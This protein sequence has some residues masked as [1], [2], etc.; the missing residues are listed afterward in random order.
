MRGSQNISAPPP[1]SANVPS[2]PALAAISAPSPL[3][4]RVQAQRPDGAR[5]RILERLRHLL[6]TITRRFQPAP[7]LCKRLGRDAGERL[8]RPVVKRVAYILRQCV[9]NSDVPVGVAD[10]LDH[11]AR[12]AHHLSDHELTAT[13]ADVLRK[14]NQAFLLRMLNV[15]NSATATEVRARIPDHATGDRLDLIK[16]CIEQALPRAVVAD[17]IKSAQNA[18]EHARPARSTQLLREALEG[19]PATLA[20]Y[21][22][23]PDPREQRG[24]VARQ[25]ETLEPWVLAGILHHAHT[26][27]LVRL[28][29]DLVLRDAVNKELLNRTGVLATRLRQQVRSFTPTHDDPAAFVQELAEM[30]ATLDEL[31]VFRQTF[32]YLEVN[33]EPRK[34][35]DPL[36]DSQ[37][38]PIQ[39]QI[40][41]LAAAV[42]GKSHFHPGALSDEQLV[43]VSSSLRS[44][45]AKDLLGSEA[46]QSAQRRCLDRLRREFK[47]SFECAATSDGEPKPLLKRLERIADATRALAQA[48]AAFTADD[49]PDPHLAQTG[50]VVAHLQ[51]LR[52][53]DRAMLAMAFAHAQTAALIGALRTGET[54][55]REAHDERLAERFASMAQLAGTLTGEA[56]GSSQPTLTP[57]LRQTLHEAYGLVI[58]ADG[59]ATLLPPGVSPITPT[60][61][62]F[63]IQRERLLPFLKGV[64]TALSD[65]STS[66]AHS[67]PDEQLFLQLM[68]KVID[69]PRADGMRQPAGLGEKLDGDAKLRELQELKGAADRIIQSL[70]AETT[71]KI[72]VLPTDSPTV[73]AQ[74][75]TLIRTTDPVILQA[76]SV[77]QQV[78]LITALRVGLVRGE[79]LAPPLHSA[80]AKMYQATRLDPDFVAAEKR[81]R[82]LVVEQIMLDP[83]LC[84]L[85][86]KARSAWPTMDVPARMDLLGG[87]VSV[88][89][90]C[91]GFQAPRMLTVVQLEKKF[92]AQW[93]PNS[94]II[95]FNKD[96]PYFDD[97]ESAVEFAYHEN[98]HNYQFALTGAR[99]RL[100]QKDPT[101]DRRNLATQI[102]LFAA[103]IRY[104]LSGADEARQSQPIEAHAYMAGRHFARDLCRALMLQD[105]SL[106]HA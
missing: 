12:T 94:R 96:S 4:G 59:H 89:C 64:R 38:L 14:A 42:L 95:Q 34:V 77:T 55:A 47:S 100:N 56:S 1:P 58:A 81:L 54:L 66:P 30:A 61:H 18:L 13:L 97:F 74:A 15:M 52:E 75:E 29:E 102:K 69:V 6:S 46:L 16:S 91:A 44:L 2:A 65:R 62:D 85:L 84:G 90:K 31:Q 98:S 67:I 105:E 79:R 33:G 5:A 40:E 9:S 28:R 73:A 39:K 41:S 92:G 57:E 48:T 22:L 24:L 93:Q 68:R 78:E 25:L 103:T 71:P 50:L 82:K 27:D 43:R 72:V 35:L 87:I 23:R 20:A 53:Q 21:G 80:M 101:G 83:R 7:A 86:T 37:L 104:Y 8:N 76:L 11:A 17:R 88:H 51:S 99:G 106:Q 60:E 10:A 32:A 70:V 63:F 26:D 36:P 49:R 45:G 3:T 19:S